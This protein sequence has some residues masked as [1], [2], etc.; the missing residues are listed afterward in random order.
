MRRTAGSGLLTL[1]ICATVSIGCSGQQVYDVSDG[2]V[3]L[4]NSNIQTDNS[5][6]GISETDGCE[7]YSGNNPSWEKLI[8]DYAAS[9]REVRE[10]SPQ[11]APEDWQKEIQFLIDSRNPETNVS[12]KT[13]TLPFRLALLRLSEN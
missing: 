10:S 6:N 12:K 2:S 3:S 1:A 7:H 13:Y 11:S 5:F 8:N 9:V 4:P